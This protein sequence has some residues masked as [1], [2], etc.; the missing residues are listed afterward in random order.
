M[1]SMLNAV[2]LIALLMLLVSA[3]CNQPP[4]RGY[5]NGQATIKPQA[6][7][8]S[9]AESETRRQWAAPIER[10]GIPNLARVSGELYRGGQPT[11]M[12]VRQLAD[13]GV[14][15]V[16]RLTPENPNAALYEKLGI[17][18]VEIEASARMPTDVVAVRFL[19]AISHRENGPFFVHCWLG[20]DRA[21]LMSAIYR[22]VVQGWSRD[23]ALAEMTESCFGYT[24]FF[25]RQ[26]EWFARADFDELR[27]DA[28]I[29]VTARAEPAA[30][31]DAARATP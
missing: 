1:Q 23:E 28:D 27:S 16:I 17:R 31:P 3:G 14:R 11:P 2:S 6:R 20:V 29:S 18:V 24:E 9:D 21:A 30:A 25:D 10:P 7:V 15:T 5:E 22:V 26:K 8:E 19:E 12:G 4:V 13:M